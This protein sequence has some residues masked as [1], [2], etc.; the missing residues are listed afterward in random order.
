MGHPQTDWSLTCDAPRGV[1]LL[2]YETE[3]GYL[4]NFVDLRFDDERVSTSPFTIK[5]KLPKGREL[6]SVKLLPTGEDLDFSVAGGYLTFKTPETQ[7]FAMFEI[8]VKYF[9]QNRISY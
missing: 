5:V 2:G 8:T 4:I 7:L 1:E 9:F 3:N 6:A